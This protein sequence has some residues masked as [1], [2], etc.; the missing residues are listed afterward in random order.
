[1]GIGPFSVDTLN[2]TRYNFDMKKR[3]ENE[4]CFQTVPERD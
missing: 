3:E 4:V 1:M 2:N